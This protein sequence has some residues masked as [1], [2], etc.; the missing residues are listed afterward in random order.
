MA[1]SSWRGTVGLVKPTM[2]P[3]NLE[4]VIRM[5][6]DGI[7][8]IPLF[9]DIRKGSAEEFR[10]VIAGFEAKTAQLAEFGVDLI[11]T[12]GAPPFM[13][14]GYEAEGATVREWE[15]RFKVPIFTSG[16]NAIAAFRALNV[17]RIVGVSYTPGEINKVYARYFV[18]A[19][20]EVLEMSGMDVAF[21]KAQ[22]LSS[23][24]VYAFVR[25][26]FLANPSAEGIFMLGPSWHVLDIIEMLERDL[27]VPVVHQT[28]AQCWEM[29]KRLHVHEPVRGFGRL[30]AELPAL[31]G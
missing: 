30:I 12:S 19:G 17:K 21:D 5:L 2:R 26:V 7:Y 28:P 15:R 8:V 13:A 31:P 24:Q 23:R 29:Q 16:Q 20:F 11:H 27:G 9:N 22:E 10:D 1:F 18:D 6:P 3:G 4:E 14:L 25:N